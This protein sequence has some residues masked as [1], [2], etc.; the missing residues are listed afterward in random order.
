MKS[1]I[2]FDKNQD[3][4]RHSFH[5]NNH[6]LINQGFNQSDY[7]VSQKTELLDLNQDSPN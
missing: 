6:H 5:S 3:T 7:I 1:K 2:K 4:N